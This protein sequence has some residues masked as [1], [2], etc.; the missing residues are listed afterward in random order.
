M[1]IILDAIA[2]SLQDR[3]GVT[4]YFSEILRSLK[5]FTDYKLINDFESNNIF[6][7]GVRGKKGSKLKILSLKYSYNNFSS[8][9]NYIYHS[10]YFTVSKNKNA[11]NILTIHDC[12]YEKFYPFFKKTIHVFFK[13]RALNKAS[14][15]IFVSQ[16]TKKDMLEIYPEISNKQLKVITHGL[17]KDFFYDPEII[18][19]KRLLYISGR[20]YYKRFE[21]LVEAMKY[22]PEYELFIV[23]GGK[24]SKKELKLLTKSKS[25]YKHLSNIN[26]EELNNIYNSSHCLVYT[27][28][29]EG[30]GLPVLESIGA[31]CPVICENNSSLPEIVGDDYDLLCDNLSPPSIVHCIKKLEDKTYRLNVVNQGLKSATKFSWDQSA[32]SLLNFYKDVFKLKD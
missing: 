18:V 17:S 21:M 10:S 19:K 16:S 13:K 4:M 9:K 29:Y 24:L 2:F 1:K 15:I 11:V 26:N 7:S 5:K 8:N 3:G 23:G 14:G 31:G 22:I 30:F 28:E 25:T 6:H 27:S 32:S 12:M 20:K